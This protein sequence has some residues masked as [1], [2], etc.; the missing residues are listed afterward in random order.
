[1]ENSPCCVDNRIHRRSDLRH[2][3]YGE[4]QTDAA[5]SH[6]RDNGGVVSVTTLE[7]RRWTAGLRYLGRVLLIA[8]DLIGIFV[9]AITGA[10]DGVKKHLDVFGVIV[11]AVVS[12][13]G[14]GLVRD[15]LLGATPPAALLDWRYLVMPLPAA[16][17]AF[18]RSDRVVRAAEPLMILDAIGLGLFAVAGTRKALNAGLSGIASLGIGMITAI[19]G[20]LLRDVLL[21]EVPRTLR[22][23]EPYALAALFGSLVV[24]FADGANLPQSGSAVAGAVV[25]FAVRMIGQRRQWRTTIAPSQ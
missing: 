5:R 9:M 6:R 17:I 10:L 18:R 16:L 14:G 12:A 22:P 3:L 7:S 25:V 21:R 15:V 19:G 2:L 4:R 8:L 24:V 13:L 23:S 20:G 11:I 1:M